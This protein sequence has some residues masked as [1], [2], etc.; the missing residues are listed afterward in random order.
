M[1]DKILMKIKNNNFNTLYL[2]IIIFL[3][4]T[5]LISNNST[6]GAYYFVK[7]T[8]IDILL[9]VISLIFAGC[10][11]FSSKKINKWRISL[12][13]LFL[14]CISFGFINASHLYYLGFRGIESKITICLIINLFLISMCLLN[15]KL[16]YII[17]V[18]IGINFLFTLPL[19]LNSFH[20]MF[21]YSGNIFESADYHVM[22]SY[23]F[24]MILIFFS[25]I[26]IKVPMYLDVKLELKKLNKK[27]SK[28]KIT[29]EEYTNIK[30]LLVDS[31]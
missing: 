9:A 31:I 21:S 2:G 19:G 26:N 22:I 20:R 10:I 27:K 18:A 1:K 7:L 23:F 28:N 11:T 14:S 15:L 6:V 4:I 8:F 16:K 12:I 13:L 24:E 5:M 29:Q 30:Q 17:M 25:L 3:F